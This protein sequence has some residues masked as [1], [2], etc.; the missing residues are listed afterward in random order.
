MIF[1]RRVHPRLFG[2]AVALLLLVPGSARGQVNG[3]GAEA[4]Q[5]ENR[6]RELQEIERD[7]RLRANPAI[8]P[9]QRTYLDYGGFLS[10]NYLSLDDASHDNHGLRDYELVG[11]LRGVFDGANEIFVRGR[12]EYRDYN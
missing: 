5:Q 3:S 10:F 12:T 1:A 6:L 2:G 8:P 9:G 11:Y 4:L 7:T